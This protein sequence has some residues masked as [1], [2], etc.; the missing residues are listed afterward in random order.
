MTIGPAPMIRTD[1]MSVRLGM[2]VKLLRGPPAL[3]C[4][5]SP[6][7]VLSG[8]VSGL[9]ACGARYACEYHSSLSLHH[10]DEAIE[11]IADVVRTW[12]GFRMALKAERR[13]V[14]T[15]DPLQAAVEQ[16]HVRHADVLRQR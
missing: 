12:T 15:R 4:H 13:P 6:L 11:Q 8:T 5:R 16:R 3:L 10:L 2:V 1:S 9:A 14:R 7:V